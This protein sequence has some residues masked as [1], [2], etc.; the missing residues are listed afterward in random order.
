MGQTLIGFTGRQIPIPDFEQRGRFEADQQLAPAAAA[1]LPQLDRF[2]GRD[3]AGR[4]FL[5]CL[6]KAGDRN[7]QCVG[8][9]AKG[10]NAGIGAALLDLHQHPLAD[11]RFARELIEGQAAGHA[12]LV[13]AAGDAAVEGGDIVHMTIV[14]IY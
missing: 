9:P 13:Q 7:T 3:E 4:R 10:G 5:Y 2:A 1:A 6:D 8:D 12:N 11:A 14:S